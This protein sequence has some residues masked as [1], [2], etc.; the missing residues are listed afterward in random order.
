MHKQMHQTSI[1]EIA[2]PTCVLLL[3]KN[4]DPL[5]F[6]NLAWNPSLSIMFLPYSA[7]LAPHKVM[8]HVSKFPLMVRFQIF[9]SNSPPLSSISIKGILS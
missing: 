4:F 2:P 3:S 5:E 1:H 8:N 6:F 9:V 7:E